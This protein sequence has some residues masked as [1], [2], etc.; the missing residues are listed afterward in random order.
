M[1]SKVY[2]DSERLPIVK[3][4][5]EVCKIL[6]MENAMNTLILLKRREEKR[7][8]R[9]GR[10]GKRREEKRRE[11]KRREEKRDST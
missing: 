4:T 6:G 2:Y 9:K 11:E 7:T 8:E 3:G 5:K 1:R 10:E